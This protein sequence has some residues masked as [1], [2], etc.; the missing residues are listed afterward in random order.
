MKAVVSFGEGGEQ[1]LCM[2]RNNEL[3]I[4]VTDGEGGTIAFVGLDEATTREV[5]E[6][7][8]QEVRLIGEQGIELR[9]VEGGVA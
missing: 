2:V 5:L 6:L 1:T 7:L 3:V 9:A 4:D 8:R